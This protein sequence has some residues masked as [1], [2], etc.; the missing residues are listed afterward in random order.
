MKQNVNQHHTFPRKQTKVQVNKNYFSSFSFQIETHPESFLKPGSL[1]TGEANSRCHCISYPKH[2]SVL[3]KFLQNTPPWYPA[4]TF[5]T[6]YLENT[7]GGK[8]ATNDS[9]CQS[10]GF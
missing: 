10:I 4:S 1:K 3:T 7:V 2:R 8:A 5:A 9:H 6:D